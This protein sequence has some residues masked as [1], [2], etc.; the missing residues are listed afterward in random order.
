MVKMPERPGFGDV[1][2]SLAEIGQIEGEE[3]ETVERHR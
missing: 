1:E 2:V 3:R